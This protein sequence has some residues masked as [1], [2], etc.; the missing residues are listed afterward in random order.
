MEKTLYELIK[1]YKCCICD[2]LL[3]IPPIVILN[4]DEGKELYKCGRC[5]WIIYG[6]SRWS[7]NRF[8]EEVAQ[9]LYFSCPY[10]LCLKRI[11][12]RRLEEHEEN[13]H[14]RTIRCPLFDDN[15]CRNILVEGIADHFEN[16]HKKVIRLVESTGNSFEVLNDT[17]NILLLQKENMFFFVYI[18]EESMVAVLATRRSKY[19]K[20]SVKLKL[21]PNDNFVVSFDD[22]PVIT[23]D[24]K[25]HCFM[26]IQEICHENH[27]RLKN[28][29]N[30]NI[31]TSYFTS[32]LKNDLTRNSIYK[33]EVRYFIK[34]I[35]D[36]TITEDPDQMTEEED[37]NE[38]KFASQSNVEAVRRALSC[39]YCMAYMTA[40]IFTCVTG[41]TFCNEC[42]P[43]LQKCPTCQASLDGSRNYTLEEMANDMKVS[44]QFDVNGC[45]FFDSTSNMRIHELECS[46]K[47]LPRNE[48]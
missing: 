9:K 36:E 46:L 40:P 27:T 29:E 31:D 11:P 44:C 39:P 33:D 19:T 13:C 28:I 12:Q 20:F 2:R 25:Y 43:R 5:K 30:N 35:A 26:C 38:G 32:D 14:Y 47:D 37:R 4:V 17:N 7:R 18:L 24:D 16:K 45:T 3:S 15:C 48:T 6:T 42:K 1:K 34:M 21:R 22:L 8:L 41:H 23:Y 10:P